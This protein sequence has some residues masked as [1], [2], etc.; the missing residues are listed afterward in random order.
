[1]NVDTLGVQPLYFTVKFGAAM[2]QLGVGIYWEG[3][4]PKLRVEARW[5][6]VTTCC[7]VDEESGDLPISTICFIASSFLGSA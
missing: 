2:F 5:T 1:M 6:E 4:Y 7:V 3:M